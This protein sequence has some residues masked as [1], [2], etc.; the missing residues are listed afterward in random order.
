[1]TSFAS[2][3]D[4]TE[5]VPELV[6]LGPGV[7]GYISDFD[8]NAGFIVG[9]AGVIVIDARATPRMGR[10]FVSAIRS[11]TD[12][13]ILGV[14]LTHYH[15]V[16][17]LGASAFAHEGP[18]GTT[19]WIAASAAT[20]AL[21]AE[22]GAED[23]ESETRRFPRLFQGVEEIHGL[24]WPTLTFPERMSVWLGKREVIFAHI[25]RGHT[26]GDTIC[27]V[28]DCGVI[29]AGDLVEN[30]CAAY[31]GDAHL[32]DWPTTLDRLAALH[33][34][35]LVPGRGAAATTPEAA[36]HAIASTRAFLLAL[37]DATRDALATHS[38]DDLH[39][40]FHAVAAT[41]RP[42][43]GDWPIFEHCLPFNVARAV[44]EI[45]G[46][47]HPHVWTAARDRALWERLRG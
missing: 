24:T 29:F 47:D 30:R 25:G 3:D 28:P 13:P 9:D 19:P 42:T 1:M 44:D 15:A 4:M 17:V 23:W 39:P 12:R 20:R 14:L 37:T 35:A 40:I 36:A 32:T 2:T 18:D 16:R 8:P 21:I 7:F 6:E 31:T 11:V 34:A 26:A 22:R 5:Q 43:Y 46:A 10:A 41:M 45:T 33:P 27:H 38:P